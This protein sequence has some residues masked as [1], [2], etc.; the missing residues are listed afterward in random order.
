MI[1][2]FI[3]LYIASII[4][5]FCSVI[6]K[7]IDFS[8]IGLLC[9]MTPVVNT[10]MAILFLVALLKSNSFGAVFNNTKKILRDLFTIDLK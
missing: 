1:I 6:Y 8:L 2:F 3:L 10:I 5:S 7:E 4:G 9:I